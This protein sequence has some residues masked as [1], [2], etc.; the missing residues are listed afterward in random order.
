MANPSTVYKQKTIGL[1]L[2]K[3]CFGNAVYRRIVREQNNLHDSPIHRTRLKTVFIVGGPIKS[4][5]T[6]YGL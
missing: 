6:S 5:L 2:S 1:L 3:Q 4:T